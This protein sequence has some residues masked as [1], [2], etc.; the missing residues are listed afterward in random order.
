ME[1]GKKTM[2]KLQFEKSWDKALSEQDRARINQVFSETK[3][4]KNVGVQFIRIREAENYK[5]E[6]LVM[7]LIHNPTRE[8]FIFRN[9]M[10]RYLENK[11]VI[12]EHSFTFPALISE[13]ETSM[14]WTFIF[15]VESHKSKP[16][17]ENGRLEMS[18]HNN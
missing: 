2:Q 9:T 17:Y 18:P 13:P 7:V 5:G 8:A 10:L 1:E 15:P 11:E 16:T 6:I 14:P 3:D 4:I 12:A